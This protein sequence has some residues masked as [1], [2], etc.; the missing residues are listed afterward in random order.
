[1]NHARI[2]PH[3]GKSPPL[4]RLWEMGMGPHNESVLIFEGDTLRRRTTDEEGSTKV[5]A[6]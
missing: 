2:L 1:M 6:S 4:L 5:Q 3:D